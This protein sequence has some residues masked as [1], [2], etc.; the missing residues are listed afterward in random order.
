MAKVNW[1]SQNKWNLSVS[2]QLLVIILIISS[3]FTI[4][5]SSLSLYFDYR[6]DI[7]DIQALFLQ[8]EDSDVSALS[9]SLWV[10]DRAQLSIQAQGIMQLPGISYLQITDGEEEIIAFGQQL[11]DKV[12]EKAWRLEYATSKKNYQLATLLVQSD[13]SIIYDNL[14][15]KGMILLV[16]YALLVFCI[17]VA[18]L[19]VAYRLIVSPLTLMAKTVTEFDEQQVPVPIALPPRWFQDEISLLAARYNQSVSHIQET[20]QQL[21]LA[22]QQAE[23]ANLKKSE[24]LANMSHEIRTPMNGIIGLSGIMLEMKMPSDQKEYITMLHSS[25]LSLLDLINDIL[26]FSKIEA[27]KMEVNVM[28]VNLFSLAKEVES[29]FVV[30]AAEKGIGL[31]C[32][33]ESSVSPLLMGDGSKLRQVL[34]NL[35]SNAVK[36]TQ[37]GL[38]SL[39]VQ[40]KEAT[41]EQCRVQ[42]S[43]QDTGIGIDPAQ[44]ALV[45]EKFQQAD[46]S[47]TRQYGGTGLGLAICREM[48]QLM[49]G[50][51]TLDSALGEGCCF[52]FTLCFAYGEAT[53]GQ[54]YPELQDKH[55]LLVDDSR[56]NMRITTSQLAVQGVTAISC[57]NPHHALD[58]IIRAER[59]G[60]P[61]D[62][63]IID[64]WMPQMGGFQLASKLTESLGEQCP[65]LLMISAAP[66]HGDEERAAM[67]GI[68]TFMARPYKA[69]HLYWV[70]EQLIS[71]SS[72]VTKPSALPEKCETQSVESDVKAIGE[73]SLSPSPSIYSAK[74][75][76]ASNDKKVT[77]GLHCA[78][79][80]K[81]SSVIL[82]VEDTV[83]NQKVARLMLEKLG[84]EVH[85]A[86]NGQVAL[87]MMQEHDFDLIFMDCQMP[88]LDGFAATQAIRERESDGEHIP[89]IALTANV[90]KEEKEKCLAA[91]M[92]DFVSKPVSKQILAEML[93]KHCCLS[94]TFET[95]QE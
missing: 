26:D 77:S 29:L 49:G 68:Q 22:R 45:F 39:S 44:H 28:P 94:E 87:N 1:Q 91:G 8:I 40:H 7:A 10:E 43:I 78:E 19:F 59:A 24:F 37:Q 15:K 5:S 64:K 50:E 67:S 34:T 81:A 16:G 56:L 75:P 54:S 4:L 79:S 92:D 52:S 61:F 93:K 55:V 31:S 65:N 23:K 95:T 17:S 27:G 6:S 86:E 74:T 76:V 21:E 63:V 83:V 69:E 71:A 88:V 32:S 36:F 11:T 35:L 89:I 46:G 60:Q 14:L 12:A 30:K 85:V 53:E 80:A 58:E 72:T 20:Y 3:V 66:E 48:V 38:V 70:L 47:T 73:Q 90:V 33:V 57:H 82:V 84:A 51:L 9:A 62:V 2:K 13:L 25:S 42:F 41:A 18:I